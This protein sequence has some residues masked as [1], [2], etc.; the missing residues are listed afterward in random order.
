[1]LVK[2][3]HTSH[4]FWFFLSYLITTVFMYLGCLKIFC[5]CEIKLSRYY[6]P[7]VEL[8]FE[9]FFLRFLKSSSST[10]S[11]TVCILVVELPSPP[12]DFR[13]SFFLEKFHMDYL[14]Y[15]SSKKQFCKLLVMSSLNTQ[16]CIRR[17]L[18]STLKFDDLSISLGVVHEL[19]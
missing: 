2:F 6:E 1:M 12:V 11:L 14:M 17:P 4:R 13:L 15:Y 16:S 10:R 7:V 9:D 8:F 19:R 3:W 5:N 18:C